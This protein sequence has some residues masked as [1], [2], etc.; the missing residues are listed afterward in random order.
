[1]R[2]DAIRIG[3]NPPHDPV[4]IGKGLLAVWWTWIGPLLMVVGSGL[5][6]RD[7]HSRVGTL[8]ALAGCVALTLT[9]G[10]QMV[11]LWRNVSDPLVAKSATLYAFY[12]VAVIATVLADAGAVRLCRR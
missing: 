11:L 1:M 10:Y 7:T 3:N 12:A 2:I 9:V 6:L 4:L 8:S 5:L